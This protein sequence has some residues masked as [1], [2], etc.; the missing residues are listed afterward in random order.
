[1]EKPEWYN[2]MQNNKISAFMGL[3]LLNNM[4]NSMLATGA[5]EISVD[6]VVIYS[7]LQ[8]NRLPNANDIQAALASIGYR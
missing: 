1:M 2:W 5:F 8:T 6:D 3:F 7:K 4:G